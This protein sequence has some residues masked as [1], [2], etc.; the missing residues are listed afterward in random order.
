[1]I[2]SSNIDSSKVFSKQSPREFISVIKLLSL[3][4]IKPLSWNH[5]VKEIDVD[6]NPCFSVLEL[7]AEQFRD[8]RVSAI[9]KNGYFVIPI[10]SSLTVL[11]FLSLWDQPIESYVYGVIF[12]STASLIIST[13]GSLT[14]NVASG[15]LIGLVGGISSGIAHGFGDSEGAMITTELNAFAHQIF[16]NVSL[17]V[18]IGTGYWAVLLSS[19]VAAAAIINIAKSSQ[20]TKI[21]RKISSII[22]GATVGALMLFLIIILVSFV[23]IYSVSIA[24]GL[25]S[26]FVIWVQ[27]KQWLTSLA[28]GL[29]IGGLN[30]LGSIIFWM[31]DPERLGFT[32][33]YAQ[34]AARS[35]THASLE[36]IFFVLIF[37]APYVIAKTMADEISGAVAGVLG[38]AGGYMG[39]AIAS[40]NYSLWPDALIGMMIILIGITITWWVPI[41]LYPVSLI[42]DSSIYFI[43]KNSTDKFSGS[44]I[45][46]NSVFWTELQYLPLWG[47]DNHLLLLLE[48]NYEQGKSVLEFLSYSQQRWAVRAAQ[49][50]FDA[51]D[52]G[53]R[54]TIAD[55]RNA[56]KRFS[57]PNI[58]LL[59]GQAETILYSF[60][61][62][63]EDIDAALK[64]KNN[65]N[66]RLSLTHSVDRLGALLRELNRIS[67]QYAVRF[68]PIVSGWLSAVN[69]Q[70]EQITNSLG[71]RQ[72]I[73]SPYIVG[74]PIAQQQDIF[75]GRVDIA[76]RIENLLIQHSQSP[77]VLLYGQR[78]MGKTSLINNF[79]RL[80]TSSIIPMFVDLQGPASSA[81]RDVGFLYGMAKS[82]AIS[83]KKSRDIDLH[84]PAYSDFELDPFVVFNDWLDDLEACFKDKIILIAL[85]EFE[86][87]ATS[88]SRNQL[89]EADILG[90]FRNLIQ[91]RSQFRVLLSGSHTLD[92]F[93][94][95]SNYLI[96][97]KVFKVGYLNPA[98]S[99]QLIVSP[100]EDFQLC[101]ESDA[102]ERVIQLTRGHPYLIQLLCDEI[103]FLKNEQTYANRHLVTESDVEQAAANALEVGE[104]FF[105][106]IE[107]QVEPLGLQFLRDLAALATPSQ[108]GLNAAVRETFSCKFDTLEDLTQP[109]CRLDIIEP[110]GNFYRFQV[111]LIRHWFYRNV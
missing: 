72:E 89:S 22:F 48:R 81:K 77:P 4:T 32:N 12:G 62:I 24:I 34:I 94:Q 47:L 36:S 102:V 15:L 107:S 88:F 71:E 61:R 110:Y 30:L 49:I 37:S 21:H 6:L 59:K 19:S 101:Y 73:I 44:L 69:G 79:G 75:V 53:N 98:E 41:L 35:I 14:T 39:L 103:I 95:W 76:K 74:V 31:G 27:T 55:I 96:N 10:L 106:F 7:K 40:E 16:S 109:L 57:F 17:S 33:S 90:L 45:Y 42:W 58:G 8:S 67:D 3:L 111:E 29:L 68:I 105:S 70:I 50:E 93:Q 86:V 97:A 66:K 23:G 64:Q 43:D 28:L 56:Y 83:A 38:S 51:R 63:S 80:L 52:L 60:S 5:L 11:I 99:Y 18:D 100:I 54:K 92:Q 26:A 65:Y 82:M 13:L 87:L 1:M 84:Y 46:L 25:L 108:T 104:L 9:L 85:D 20:G 2:E 78:R 91:H